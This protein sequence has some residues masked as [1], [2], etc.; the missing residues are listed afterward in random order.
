MGELHGRGGV[1]FAGAAVGEGTEDTEFGYGERGRDKGAGIG[2]QVPLG[3]TP[4]GGE[5]VE[6][7]ELENKKLPGKAE[8]AD[9][10]EEVDTQSL[11]QEM[12]KR[13]KLQKR[14]R[15]A[16]EKLKE[17]WQ[18]QAKYKR[19]VVDWQ[20]HGGAGRVPK[21]PSEEPAG[22]DQSNL[23]DP[24][25]RLMKKNQRADFE[26]SYNAQATVDAEGSQLVV[27]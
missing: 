8:E 4:A 12:R 9:C 20:E 3:D 16:L 15:A 26:Q 27:G 7:L 25:S 2:Q 22:K 17:A 19:K 18:E 23:K 14:L 6:E 24:D 1:F 21:P 11:P 10:Q 13:E 5:P